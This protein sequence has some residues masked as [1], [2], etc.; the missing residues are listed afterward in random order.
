MFKMYCFQFGTDGPS[1]SSREK[2]CIWRCKIIIVQMHAGCQIDAY[3]RMWAGLYTSMPTIYINHM[4]LILGIY[5]NLFRLSPLIGG[6]LIIVKFAISRAQPHNVN[7]RS[8]YQIDSSSTEPCP[9]RCDSSILV[10]C[11]SVLDLEEWVVELFHDFAG[12]H[13]TRSSGTRLHN[14]IIEVWSSYRTFQRSLR[15]NPYVLKSSIQS[16]STCNH[17]MLSCTLDQELHSLTV[18]SNLDS[19]WEFDILFEMWRLNS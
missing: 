13:Q 19:H 3:I 16:Q 18:W 9:T 8:E 17:F 7:G 14:L 2:R 15:Q 11:F 6:T 10:H 4:S 5:S 1:A 12:D